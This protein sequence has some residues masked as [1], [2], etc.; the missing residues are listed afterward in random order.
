M[1][2]IEIMPLYE[3]ECLDCKSTFEQLV[4]SVGETDGLAC[5]HCG[6]SN[7]RKIISAGSHRLNVTGRGPSLANAAPGPACPSGSRFR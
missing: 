1:G 6:S 7:I 3:F 4:K 5:R 2:E